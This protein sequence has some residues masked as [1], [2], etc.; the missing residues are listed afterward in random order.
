MKGLVKC[1]ERNIR[2]EDISDGKLYGNNDMVKAD[3]GNCQGCS[4]CCRGMGKSI[5]LDPFDIYHLTIHLHKSMEELLNS[6]IELNVVDKIVLPNLKMA[7]KEEACSFLKEEGRCSIHEFRPGMCRLF[8]LG[9]FYENDAFGYFL[10]IHEC[11]KQN[12]SKVKVKKWIG[13]ENIKEYEAFINQW[14][15]FQKDLQKRINESTEETFIKK[16]SMYVLQ[17]FYLKPY[18]EDRDFYEQF[19]ERLQEAYENIKQW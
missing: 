17:N 10:Q 4:A 14:H 13:V 12:L 7:G 8:P 18:E 3:T 2:M 15:Y 11:K 9:R 5:I 19:E 16:V 6:Y 1:M